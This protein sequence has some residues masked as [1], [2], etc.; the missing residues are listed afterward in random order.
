MAEINRSSQEE[1]QEEVFEI[2]LSVLIRDILRSFGKLWW[3]TALLAAICA[4]VSLFYGIRSYQPLYKAEAT[5]TVETYT[6][7]SGYTFFYDNHTAAQMALTFPYLLDSDLLLDRVKID[8][9]VE[10]LNGMPSATV[11]ENSNLFTL[12]VTSSDPQAAYDILQALIKNYPIVAEYVIGRTQLNMIDYPEFP[13]MPYNS[14][15]H[16]KSAA[17]GGMIGFV[18]GMG[19]IFLHA[20]MRNTVR[21]EKDIH[22]KL[23]TSC[24]GSVPLVNLRRSRKKQNMMLSIHNHKVGTPFRESFRGMAL[25]IE[26]SLE[27]KKV[28]MITATGKGEGTSAV[29]QN[30]AFALADRGMRVALIDGNLQHTSPLKRGLEEYLQGKQSMEQL[31][32]Q[33]EQDSI[34]TMGCGRALSSKECSLAVKSFAKLVQYLKEQVDYVLIDTPPCQNLD[35]VSN[36]AEQAEA[37]LYVIRQDT[38]KLPKIMNCFEDLNHFEAKIIGCVLNGVRHGITGYGYGYSYGYGYGY[39]RGYRYG[40]YSDYGYEEGKNNKNKQTEFENE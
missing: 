32:Q 33:S 23:Q 15:Q 35:Q 28:L 21:K 26:R 3:L 7:Q 17:W 18:L 37:I 14:T 9:G 38:V 27:Q 29:A 4:A 13:S 1:V 20:L 16:L 5:F 8:L 11:I 24:V 22:E 40:R 36:I 6:T 19:I 2:D 34:Y 30:L 25:Q 31:F 12:S 39:G 10:Y